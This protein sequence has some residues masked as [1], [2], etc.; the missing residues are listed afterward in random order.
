MQSRREILFLYDIRKGNPNGDPDE[1]RPRVFP[2]GTF[3]VTDVRLK[4]Y[5]RDYAKQQGHNILVDKVGDLTTD[6]GGRLKQHFQDKGEKPPAGEELVKSILDCFVDARMFGSSLAIKEDKSWKAKPVPKTLTGPVQF[7]HGEVLHDASEIE[8]YGTSV[9]ASGAEKTQGTFT[10]YYGLQYGLIGFHG[11]VNEHSAKIT[12]MK[13][14]D[15]ELLLEG[16]WK[17]V[18]SAGNTRTKLDQVPRLLLS[19]EY[20]EDS[21][22]QL[23][24]LLGRLSVSAQTG[25]PQNHWKSIQDLKLEVDKLIAD[26]KRVESKVEKIRIQKCPDLTISSDFSGVELMDLDGLGES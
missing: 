20:K 10:S 19:I 26:L 15:Y 9:F 23:G 5:V 21:D 3:Y 11:I 1:N 8:I 22:F 25:K 7:N 4:R 2:D 14:K 6:L 17:G 16:L 24:D 12:G 18:R 13:D